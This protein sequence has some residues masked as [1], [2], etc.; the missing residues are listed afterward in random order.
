MAHQLTS[1][2]TDPQRDERLHLEYVQNRLDEAISR[3][4]TR[5]KQY[6]QNIED[7]KNYLWESRAD[8]DHVEKVTTR[9]SIEQMVMTGETILAQKQ[10]LQ[11]LARSPYFGRFDFIATAES[12]PAGFY[13]GVNHFY[14]E[15]T[16]E[17]LIYDWRAPVATLFY[18]FEIGPAAYQ[19]PSGRIE[20]NISLKRQFRIR[21]GAMEM[22][23][24]T[25]LHIVDD[26]LQKELAG[27]ADAGM[28]NIVATIQ[29]DQNAIIRNEDAPTL[30]IQGVA[31]SG[32]T[33]IALHRIAFLLYRF[34][35]SLK[36]TDILIISPNKVFADYIANVLP[37]LG[38]ESI[39]EI[40]MD[41][42]AHSLLDNKVP[43]QTFFEQTS[44]LLETNDEK[45]KERI[46]HKSSAQFLNKLGEYA[47]YI[48]KSRFSAEDIVVV[49]RPV[50][51]WFIEKHFSRYRGLPPAQRITEVVKA[52]EVNMGIYYNVDLSAEDRRLV[53]TAINKMCRKKSLNILY[54]EFFD[55]LGRPD[56]FVQAKGR[57]LEYADVFPL[58]YL[59]MRLE[60]VD[61]PYRAIKHLV[62]D[63][64]QDYT[65][66]QFA[67]LARL[68]NCR[69]TIL[70]DVAQAV[71]PYS[72]SQLKDIEGAFTNATL[73]TL[74]KSYRSTLQ[75]MEFAQQICFNPQLIPMK[76]HGDV[77]TVHRLGSA[78]EEI[79]WLKTYVADFIA[80]EHSSL[81]VICKTQKQAQQITNA[82]TKNDIDARLL[83]PSS[84]VFS[85]GIIVC[86]AHMAKGL[87]FDHVV[88]PSANATIYHTE[89]D[90]NMLYVACTR[91]MH[92]LILTYTGEPSIFLTLSE[93]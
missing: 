7:Q 40:G 38:E 36:S 29:R 55:W 43:F 25:D 88:I 76:R 56:L 62:I 77:P 83:D 35:E 21:D 57:K 26:V 5:L 37:E 2:S 30:I 92:R 14:N 9:Q 68:F 49:G 67:V 65:P 71:N 59:K 78:K 50:P 87:E 51:A 41:D 70:G 3:I 28:K 54:K 10:Q 33:S 44:V 11:K 86:T 93:E 39:A 75:I 82:L 47:D 13:I 6:R 90:R 17:H 69:K 23:L 4:D 80:S 66:V 46:Q 19:S 60:N 1:T 27:S 31:G 18:D 79:T 32:K 58:I 53:R 15:S 42:L 61:N 72:A 91:A 34:K 24:E 85:T 89:M 84:Q 8:M 64:M 12:Q 52:V 45:I 73:M 74:T 16:K 48:E 63:E 81:G 20:G 22:M